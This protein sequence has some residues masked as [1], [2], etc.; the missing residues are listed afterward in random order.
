METEVWSI[1][2]ADQSVSLEFEQMSICA[3]ATANNFKTLNRFLFSIPDNEAVL[4]VISGAE[5]ITTNLRYWAKFAKIHLRKSSSLVRTSCS[6]LLPH[7]EN[8]SLE[9]LVSEMT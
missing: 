3:S 8:Q 6:L 4:L 5:G 7:T 2:F 1:F 9:T